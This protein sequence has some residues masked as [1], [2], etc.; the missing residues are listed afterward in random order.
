MPGPF[1]REVYD[2]DLFDDY[3]C[4]I[5]V[6]SCPHRF[7]THWACC[8][9]RQCIEPIIN[10]TSEHRPFVG[11]V[12]NKAWGE[13]ARQK[14]YNV[15]HPAPYYGVGV[16]KGSPSDRCGYTAVSSV[17]FAL[18]QASG[19]PVHVFGMDYAVGKCDFNNFKGDHSVNRF[20]KESE[21]LRKYWQPHIQ[22]FGR[23]E[24]SI[25]DYIRGARDEFPLS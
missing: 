20:K 7:K 10:G 1:V 6:N 15:V 21:W 16:P 12:T 5:G 4:V 13:K 23:I 2:D 18:S 8:V 25:L 22:V 24:P 3:D 17:W 19:G 14:G 9:D 11:V